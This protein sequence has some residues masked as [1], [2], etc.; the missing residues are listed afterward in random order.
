MQSTSLLLQSIPTKL[1]SRLNTK[2]S[3]Q[4][5]V[6]FWVFVATRI[7]VNARVHR[8]MRANV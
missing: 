3:Q 4:V 1:E 2:A 8:K 7:F 6:H 5:L